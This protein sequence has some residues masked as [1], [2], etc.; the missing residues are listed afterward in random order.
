MS[1]TSRALTRWA[2]WILVL[3]GAALLGSWLLRQHVLHLLVRFGPGGAGRVALYDRLAASQAVT[4]IAALLGA[5]V[6]VILYYL[7]E[8]GWQAA[9]SRGLIPAALAG[10]L[11]AAARP[12]I[13]VVLRAPDAAGTAQQ[14]GDEVF[15]MLA[16]PDKLENFFHG[17]GAAV[18]VLRKRNGSSLKLAR[19]KPGAYEEGA[20]DC[21]SYVLSL[22]RGRRTVHCY[23]T[24]G[25]DRQW[26]SANGDWAFCRFAL[27]HVGLEEPLD[28]DLTF[29]GSRSEL[30]RI[31]LRS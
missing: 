1:K 24:A 25:K 6:A 13:R 26:R 27:T 4:L 20:P 12:R 5:A 19:R 14:H 31:F 8:K 16:A 23:E 18:L 21:G 11:P 29:S 10:V 28:A 7:L 15:E 3:A 17:R 30:K 22:R 9:R 2:P